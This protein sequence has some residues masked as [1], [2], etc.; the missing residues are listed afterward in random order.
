VVAPA[1]TPYPGTIALTVNLSNTTDRVVRVNE[2]LPVRAGKLT[3]LYPQWIPGDHAPEGPIQSMAGLVITANGQRIP[4]MRDRVNMYAFHVHVP[5]ETTSLHVKFDYL[6]PIQPEDGM[7]LMSRLMADLEWNTVVLYPAGHYSRD[8]HVTPSAVLPA[9]WKYATALTTESKDGD[10]IRFKQTTL[11]TLVDSPLA[12]GEYYRRV[13]L[14]TGPANPVFLDV[15]ADQAKDLKITPE[16]LEMHKNLVVQA[17]RLFHSHHYNHYDFLFWLSNTLGE[18][19]LEHHQSS[20]DGISTN[21]FTDWKAG[22]YERDLLAHEYTH[23]WN[24][25][26]RRPN[27]LW[28]PAFNMPEQDNL[29]WVYEGLTQ[30]WGEVLTARSGLRTPEQTRDILARIAASFEDSPGREWRPLIDTTNQEIISERR[31]VSWVSWQR[32]ED[33]YMEGVLIW[34]DADTKI[35][36]LSGGK[37]SLDDF[38]AYSSDVGTDYGDVGSRRSEATLDCLL[39]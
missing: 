39:Q 12:A 17:Q 30:Y 32:Q 4:W 26:F 23:S 33:Y 3:L 27:D 7:V 28:R 21:Y 36:E 14:S 31:P 22:V 18:Q 13:N 29:L 6:S 9:G 25:K 5:A 8:I 38:A 1:D 2:T 19:G 35:R 24:G 11:N 20:E 15:F 10:T 37:K 16:E 34:L